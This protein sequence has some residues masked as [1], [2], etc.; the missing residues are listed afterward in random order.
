M[1]TTF[2]AASAIACAVFT[3][4]A[5]AGD[6]TNFI[7][8]VQ[9][10]S[11]VQW[12]ASVAANG[13][14]NSALALDVGGAR[15][16]LWTVLS[17]PLTSYLLDTRHVDAY[18]PTAEVAIQSEDPY[19][20]VPRTRAD[21]PFT[22]NITIDGLL[23]GATV[24]EAS[25]AV[26]LLR[27][28]QSYGADGTGTNLDRSQA[29]LVS[30]AMIT[31]NGTHT[32]AYE[33]TAVPSADLT[34]ARGE[35]RFTVF[36]LADEYAPESQLAAMRVQ[37]WPVADAAIDGVSTGQKIRFQ[38]PQIT[39]TYNDLYPESQTYAQVYP[40]S[41]RLGVEGSIIP[42]S[43][44]ILNDVVPHSRVLIVSDYDSLITGDGSWTMEILTATP[45]GIDR[46]AYVTFE[47]DRTIKLNGMVS[48]ME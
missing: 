11:G 21:R 8:Q 20:V 29:T 47:V 36:A 4:A 12:D 10:P 25:K 18:S 7:R 2:A 35:E 13:E 30:Q 23:A 24:P 46:L 31:E 40:G 16:E 5:H 32:L 48:T 19:P 42:G 1:K 6:Y 41:P 22:V 9:L 17:E 44:L 3:P 26:K 37:V 28:A 34:K 27:H 15:F 38:M 43:Q 45:F 39:L 14:Q 33:L